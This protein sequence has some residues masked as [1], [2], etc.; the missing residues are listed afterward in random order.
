MLPP[1]LSGLPRAVS[2]SM[3]PYPLTAHASRSRLTREAGHSARRA[4]DGW[5]S[6]V[7]HPPLRQ[8]QP[9]R[10]MLGITHNP[11]T[12]IAFKGLL[13]MSVAI[14]V[15]LGSLVLAGAAS[16][17]SAT[18]PAAEAPAPVSEPAPQAPAP[19]SEPVPEAPAPVTEPVSETT[20]HAE[21]IVEPP[22]EAPALVTEPAPEA[23]A[24][25]EPIVEP[26][27]EAPAHA[28][29]IVEPPPEAP[30]HVEPI[31]EPP[32]K[33][34]APVTE[35]VSE[36]TAHVE[37]IAEKTKEGALV[38]PTTGQAAEAL[39]SAPAAPQQNASLPG[40]PSGPVPAE[41]ASA[42]IAPAIVTAT[43]EPSV[44]S[45]ES[46]ASIVAPVR[47]TAAQRAEDLSC[48]LSGLSG[49]A[50]DN[51]TAA[52]PGTQSF[53]APSAALVAETATTTGTGAP[54]DGGGYGGSTGGSRSVAPPPGPAPS[55]AFGGSAA[56]GSGVAL[57][58]FF[59]L[60]GLLLPSDAL[61]MRRLRLSCQPWLTAFF[62][63]IPERPG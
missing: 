40:D 58:G 61:T 53:S 38:A 29:P 63:L 46:L 1:W 7:Y 20:A 52:W 21:P 10:N 14:V 35:P 6:W 43:E 60:A 24:H 19:V 25:V 17:E 45:A 56:G 5:P 32:P 23:P 37:P 49:P 22:P 33:T 27:P 3:R 42:L 57:S 12:R 11:S 28:E 8:A 26:A 13:C 15:L 44:G 50:T 55:G 59:T 34:P 2:P 51:C 4:D 47:L 16:A 9:R 39:P 54:P 18:E 48:Q 62:V 31:V 41:A 30:A 36:T